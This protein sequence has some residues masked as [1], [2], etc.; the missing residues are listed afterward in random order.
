MAQ[1]SAISDSTHPKYFTRIIE[2]TSTGKTRVPYSY[3]VDPVTRRRGT[4]EA[5]NV[6][7]DA[8]SRIVIQF[9]R[10]WLQL[11]GRPVVVSVRGE[12]QSG[13]SSPQIEIAGYSEIGKDRPGFATV[14][15]VSDVAATASGFRWVWA[16]L[17]NALQ[18]VQDS[19]D[20]LANVVIG[21][22]ILAR[23]DAQRAYARLTLQFDTLAR[24]QLTEPD[25][26]ARSQAEQR[27]QQFR[28]GELARAA[29]TQR[30]RP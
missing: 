12:L 22:A 18:A 7:V 11:V 26:V 4:C 28:A 27:A 14:R 10:E 23:D 17:A 15:S 3:L 8:D 9:D 5:V 30:S 13:T 19:S 16:D 6:D 29:R 20:R 24:A 2:V 25:S 1:P 21:D